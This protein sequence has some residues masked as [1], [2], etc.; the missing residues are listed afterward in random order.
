MLLDALLTLTLAASNADASAKREVF[1]RADVL[2]M[3]GGPS[4]TAEVLERLRINTRLDVIE[5]KNDWNKVRSPSG[6]SGWVPA[7][8]V[9]ATPLRADELRARIPSLSGA[10]KVSALERLVALTPDA[11]EALASLRNAYTEIGKADRAGQIEK[12]LKGD[13][14]MYA[15]ACSGSDVFVIG[16]FRKRTAVSMLRPVEESTGEQDSEAQE[17]PDPLAEFEPESKELGGIPWAQLSSGEARLLEGTPFPKPRPVSRPGAYTMSGFAAIRLGECPKNGAVFFSAP[18]RAVRP[19][20]KIR[21]AVERWAKEN[22]MGDS[23]IDGFFEPL[24][25]DGTIYGVLRWTYEPEEDGKSSSGGA[26]L[27]VVSPRGAVDGVPVELYSLG[28]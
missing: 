25:G 27:I 15:A 18:A 8:L 2:R 23:Y 20:E 22:L 19:N 21:H 28:C 14:P 26:A 17:T 1:V 3:R 13:Y 4:Q 10:E 6:E 9:Q 5:E 16:R 11:P 24:R 7:A 12:Q